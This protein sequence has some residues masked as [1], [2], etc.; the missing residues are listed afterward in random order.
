MTD[1]EKLNA[2]IGK[3]ETVVPYVAAT[4]APGNRFPSKERPAWV[5]IH[6][7]RCSSSVNQLEWLLKEAKSLRESSGV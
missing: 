5:E 4:L 1:R 2:L 7:G 6:G 3:I